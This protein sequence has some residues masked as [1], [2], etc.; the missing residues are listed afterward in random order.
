MWDGVLANLTPGHQDTWVNYGNGERAPLLFIAGAEDHI[1]PAAVNKE[2]ADRYA[3]SAAHT[4]YKEFP[5]RDHY[6]VGAERLGRRRRLCPYV[7][8]GARTLEPARHRPAP[9]HGILTC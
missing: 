2:N 4:D 8:D 1:T 5:G 6:T 3:R 9:R 7:G